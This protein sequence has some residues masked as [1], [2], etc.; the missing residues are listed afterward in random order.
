MTNEQRVVEFARATDLDGWWSWALVVALLAIVLY[1]CIR[2]Y[3][4]D[5]HELPSTVAWTLIGLRLATIAAL[6]FFLFDLQQRTQRELTR[7]SELVVLVDASQS[8]SLAESDDVGSQSRA[9]RAAAIVDG[10]LVD[11]FAENHRVSIYRFGETPEPVLLES[12]GGSDDQPL[13]PTAG[14]S[15]ETSAVLVLVWFW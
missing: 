5:T 9:K 4:R 1:G 8:M 10:G 13:T 11:Q 2:F 12:G 14:K 15:R 7:S 3:R 6:V